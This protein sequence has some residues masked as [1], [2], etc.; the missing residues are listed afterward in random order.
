MQR[1]LWRDGKELQYRK[2]L[3]P[4]EFFEGLKQQEKWRKD[5]ART[6]ALFGGN[7]AG[8]TMAG[9]EYVIRK[10]LAKPRQ[11]WW[12][13]AESFADSVNIQQRKVW[14]LLPK[15]RVKY[16]KYDEINGFTNR[17]LL[18]DNKSIIIYKS[19]DQDRE[20]FGGEDLDGILFDEEPDHD[21]LKES[22]MRLVDRDGEMLFT[23]TSLK[24]VTE[25]IQDIFEGHDVLESKYAS[26]VDEVLPT[27][28]EKNG[29]KFYFLWTTENQHLNQ[30]RVIQEAKLMTRDEIKSRIYGIPINLSG[31]IYL[32]FNKNIH[33]VPFEDVPFNK[34][35][36]YHVLDPHDRKPW[37]MIWVAV[38][39]TGTAYVVDEY[40][41]RNFNE[42][43]SDDKTYNDYAEIIR[44][45]EEGLKQIFGKSVYKR[46]I[47]PNFGN[48]TVQLA[49][50]QGGQS[51]TTPKK[52]LSKRGFRFIDGIDALEAG[53]LKVRE[54][55]YWEE[56][57]GEIIVQ[58]KV[59]ITDNC[60]NTSRHLSRYS[61]GDILTSDGDVRDKVKPKEK[62]KDF[63]FIAGTMIR[64][65]K[66]QI[67]IEEINIGD[68]VETDIGLRKVLVSQIT[69]YDRPTVKVTFSN[70]AELIG[71][72]NH[73][74]FLKNGLKI[75]LDLLRYGDIMSIWEDRK[76]MTGKLAGVGICNLGQGSC[77]GKYGKN[78]MEGFPEGFIF[79]TRM[80]INLIM[81][82]L[83]LNFLRLKNIGLNI[84]ILKNA[85]K[86]C[87]TILGKA[88]NVLRRWQ[89]GIEAK[90]GER[91][92][93]IYP[94]K[95]GVRENHL[96]EFVT[97][98]V[99]N[100][101]QELLLLTNFVPINANQHGGVSLARTM[102]R[103]NVLFAVQNL[104]PINTPS[105]KPA[106]DNAVAVLSV[107]PNSKETVYNLT[108]E[109]RHRYYANDILVSNCDVVRYGIMSDW[110]Y[111]D[112]KVQF[113]PKAPKLY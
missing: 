94:R 33:I 89:N 104:R 76:L 74:V 54:A 40:P 1:K 105:Q 90:K 10:C 80:R 9:A 111:V 59:F 55:L 12:M 60:P 30:E 4:L 38:H 24:G 32:K 53:H 108:V 57:D 39:I 18:F 70:G 103:E 113:I 88:V 44:E 87:P 100:L 20:A 99:L 50:R 63:C 77:T 69:G 16:G 75:P 41:E 86:N 31:K 102:K 101:K 36:L 83:I 13:V 27:V 73:K 82:L 14:E 78:I 62:W 48:K 112:T 107:K 66:G 67:P 43:F 37:A 42:M 34:V 35:T 5:P 95:R 71:T 81:R 85:G 7:R 46:I 109:G 61:R 106:Q 93:R 29:I 96:R 25:V 49:E 6:K 84:L 8:K 26:L 17:K 58:P 92:L 72:S 3:N 56:K 11:R 98:V 47:D 28:V 19:Y 23:M 65:S 91:F 45:K 21:I 68:F 110:K 52:E 51:K 64:T 15:N 97:D 22:R 79:T 2:N